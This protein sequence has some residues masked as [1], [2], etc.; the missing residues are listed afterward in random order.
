M[1]NE[2]KNSTN[3]QDSLWN[4]SRTEN[5]EADKLIAAREQV[6]GKMEAANEIYKE[7]KKKNIP[8][9]KGE[10]EQVIKRL[11]K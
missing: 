8:L 9:S 5:T 7:M 6:K 1:I 11:S 10:R 2:I 4:L 3:I